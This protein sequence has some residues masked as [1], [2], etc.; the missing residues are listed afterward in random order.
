MFLSNSELI[1]VLR[2]ATSKE[3]LYLSRIVKEEEIKKPLSIYVLK[4]E[5][6]SIGGHTLANLCRK[7]GTSYLDLMIDVAKELKISDIKSYDN[8]VIYFDKTE[9]LKFSKDDSIEKGIKYAEE[10][11]E[12]IILKVLELSYEKMSKKEKKS[13]DEQINIVAKDFDSNKNSYLTGAAGLLTLG[14]AGGFA[15]YTFLTTSLS[16]LSLGS[17]SF[18]TYTGATTLLGIILG[19]IGWASLGGIA[20]LTLGS[21]N[22][23]K[24]IPIVATIGAIRQR[25]KFENK[26]KEAKKEFKLNIEYNDD[27]LLSKKEYN[28][29]WISQITDILLPTEKD[30]LELCTD[31]IYNEKYIW[32]LNDLNE[33]SIFY[34]GIYESYEKI[35]KKPAKAYILNIDK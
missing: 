9:S 3:L 25:I 11:E 5:I 21:P 4:E 30:I 20:I 34:K 29:Y 31:T 33:K 14:K 17:L 10:I 35:S 12:K 23:K 32:F 19:P 27:N 1:D 26:D 8:E 2:K 18:A 22:T 16:T 24:L 6:C 15:T 28:N 13:F 7:E